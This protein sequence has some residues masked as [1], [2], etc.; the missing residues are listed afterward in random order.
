VRKRLDLSGVLVVAWAAGVAGGIARDL[1]IGAVPPAAIAHWRYFAITIA[2]GLVGFFAAAQ[3]ARLKTP[4]QLFDAGPGRRRL[5]RARLR[6]RPAGVPVMVFG[7]GL[8][9]FLRLMSLY[10]G[11]RLPSS[12]SPKETD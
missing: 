6:A 1:L 5:D 4:V 7:A 11:W 9:L 10:R 8:C 12:Q 2:A 3:I